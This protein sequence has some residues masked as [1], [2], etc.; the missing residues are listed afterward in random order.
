[1]SNADLVK[2]LEQ[3]DQ[4]SQLSKKNYLSRANT[5]INVFDTTLANI[6]NKPEYYIGRIKAIYKNEKT[7]KGYFVVIMALFKYNP[8]FKASHE[9][10]FKKWSQ[11]LDIAHNIIEDE[12]I[13]NKPSARQ[14]EGYVPFSEIRDKLNNMSRS[15]PDRLLLS[16]YCLIPPARSDYNNVRIYKDKVPEEHSDNY[17]LIKGKSVK[18]ILN[19]YKTAKSFG[20]IEETLPPAL[21]KEILDSIKDSPR[22]WL[23][24]DRAGLPYSSNAFNK[25]A[26]RRL[27]SLFGKPLTI[28]LLRHSFINSLDFNNMSIQER[29]KIATFMG[30][31][32]VQ[33]QKYRLIFD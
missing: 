32:W 22:E 27:Q 16:M 24:V 26:N 18:L 15:H 11:E 33:Q 21:A 13:Q 19:E 9:E 4:L 17:I 28:G 23:F 10:D 8:E 3:T 20:K 14:K 1:M 7:R 30:H 5:L 2:S 25:Y 6:L 29:E 31:T 12:V